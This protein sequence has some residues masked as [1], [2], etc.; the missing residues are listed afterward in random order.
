MELEDIGPYEVLQTLGSGGMGTVYLARHRESGEQVALK[1]LAP[2]MSRDKGFRERFRREIAALEMLRNK[3]V[4][5]LLDSSNDDEPLLYYAMEYVEGENLA[6]RLKRVRRIPWQEVIEISVQICAALKAAHDAGVVHRDLKPSNL[7]ITKD[8]LVKLTDFGVARLFA[9]R[10]ITL[11]D[12]V[13]GTAEFMSPEQAGG[14]QAD[15][16]SDLYSLGAV[17]YAMLTGRPPFVAKAIAAVI[18][19]HQT[20]QFDVPS[21]YVELPSWLEEIVCKLLEKSP[22]DRFPNAFV[23][24]RQLQTVI[25]KVQLS[26]SDD[27]FIARSEVGASDATMASDDALNLE[28]TVAGTS[29][30]GGDLD[31]IAGPGEATLMR[32]LVRMEVEKTHAKTVVGK[33]FNNTWVLLICLAGLIYAVVYAVQNTRSD[34]ADESTTATWQSEVR[35]TI[36]RANHLHTIGQTETALAELDAIS[37]LLPE[38]GAAIL[39]SRLRARAEHLNEQLESKRELIQSRLDEAKSLAGEDGAAAREIWEQ[40]VLRYTSEPDVAALV[41][42]ARTQLES[43]RNQE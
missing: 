5:Q 31:Y 9:A 26:Q 25:P 1:V 22:E 2:E 33:L 39:R 18:R 7:M 36:D 35:R 19:M 42:V 11:P 23:V 17:I 15:K 12:T 20:H 14:Q 34:D 13:I 30:E 40:I 6:D 41:K 38:D 37:K 8:G 29:V 21:R 27:T 24:S 10:Q 28:P 16:R 3:H 32:D 43:D 4:V